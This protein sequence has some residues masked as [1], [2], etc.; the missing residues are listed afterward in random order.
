LILNLDQLGLAAAVAERLAVR[1]ASFDALDGTST[2]IPKPLFSTEA[3]RG[4][5]TYTSVGADSTIARDIT[6]RV[7]AAR[8]LAAHLTGVS[9]QNFT[10]ARG[11]AELE[12]GWVPT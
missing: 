4:T 3:D 8:S 6:F 5:P 12:V 1:A 9:G 10:V 11:I 7:S 2:R